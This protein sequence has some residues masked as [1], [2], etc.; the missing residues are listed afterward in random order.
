MAMFHE[1][2]SLPRQS[3]NAWCK[4]IGGEADRTKGSGHEVGRCHKKDEE[5]RL[6]SHY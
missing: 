6:P 5:S 3:C 1:Q 2:T 4:E